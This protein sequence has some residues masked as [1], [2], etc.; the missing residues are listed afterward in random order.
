[1]RRRQEIVTEP[2]RRED[3]NDTERQRIISYEKKGRDNDRN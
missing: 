3:K 2:D 1:M